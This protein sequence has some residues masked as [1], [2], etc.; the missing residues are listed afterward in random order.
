ML[1]SILIVA[2]I[3]GLGL[4]AGYVLRAAI[5]RN[6]PSQ[7]WRG[8]DGRPRLPLPTPPAGARFDARKLAGTPADAG[9]AAEPDGGSLRRFPWQDPKLAISCCFLGRVVSALI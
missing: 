3:F 2:A 4:A 1:F 5:S 6:R 7:A 9:G 8:F